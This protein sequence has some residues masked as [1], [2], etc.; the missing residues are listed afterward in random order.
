MRGRVP[1]HVEQWKYANLSTYAEQFPQEG[2]VGFCVEFGR[3]E[4]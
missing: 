4:K 1:I 3:V 2:E